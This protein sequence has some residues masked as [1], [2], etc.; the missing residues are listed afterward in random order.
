MAFPHPTIDVPGHWPLVSVELSR[1][2]HH[3]TLSA[4]LVRLL[5]GDPNGIPGHV[6]ATTWI[7]SPDRTSTVLVRHKTLGWSTPGGHVERHESTEDGGL[8]EL[9]EETGL[10]RFD[11]HRVGV[12]PALVHVTDTT[13]PSPHRHWNVAWLYTCDTD[14]PLSITEGARWWP[15]DALPDGPADLAS[16]LAVMLRLLADSR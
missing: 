14:A 3:D 13:N 6:C 9:E 10:T 15:V 11:V 7:V 1:L 8:R 12:G 16:C 4:E 5:D 2:Q